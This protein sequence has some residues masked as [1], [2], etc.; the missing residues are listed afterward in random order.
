MI[1]QKKVTDLAFVERHPGYDTLNNPNRLT[2]AELMPI[3]LTWRSSGVQHAI[4]S[5]AGVAGRL[6]GDASGIAVVEAPYDLSANCAYIVNADGSM[7]A[8]IP[9]QIGADRVAFYDV[10]DSGGAVAFL[11]AT[12]GKDLRIEIREA[13]GAVVRVEESR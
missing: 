2:V 10:I 12:P 5:Q 8:R 6:L 7:R 13:D 9:A 4:H 11:A 3:G 1:M